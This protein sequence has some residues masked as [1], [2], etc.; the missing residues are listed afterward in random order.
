M[1]ELGSTTRVILLELRAGAGLCAANCFSIM[2]YLYHYILGSIPLFLVHYTL[3]AVRV[4]C[5]GC[6]SAD[7][8]RTD[9]S[10]SRRR[11]SGNSSA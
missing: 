11:R 8:A 1:L 7:G 2:I 4:P 3:P 6:R 5:C 9:V 10:G